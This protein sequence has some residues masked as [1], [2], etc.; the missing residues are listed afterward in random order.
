MLRG[1]RV[2]G[3]FFAFASVITLQT[4]A[5]AQ[6]WITDEDIYR[7]YVEVTAQGGGDAETIQGSVVVPIWGSETDLF[8]ADLRG[9][10][11]DEQTAEGNW[12]LGFR[13]MIDH[14]MIIGGY[15][16]YD[17][18]HT[19]SDNNFQQLTLGLELLTVDWD[20]RVNGYIPEYKAKV[21]NGA[22]Q[23]S[24]SNGTIVVNQGIEK[25]YYGTDYEVG[26]LFGE[27]NGGDTELRGYAG[28]YF[29]DRS[30][31]GYEQ[32]AGPR[33]RAE[34][35][36]H[37][38][39]FLGSGSRLMAG[40]QYQ[41]DELRGD[42]P[43]ALLQVRI[44]FGAGGTTKLTR[45]QRRMLNPIVRDIDVITNPQASGPTEHASI[46]LNGQ[47]IRE[48]TVIDADTENVAETIDNAP[49]GPGKIIVFDGSKGDIFTT[50][51]I[52]IKDG[53]FAG[54]VFQV[55]GLNSGAIVTYGNRAKIIN[56]SDG[57]ENVFRLKDESVLTGLSIY[58]GKNAV[59]ANDRR[60][61]MIVD[62]KIFG[63]AKSGIQ[64]TDSRK[65]LVQDNWVTD[66]GSDGFSLGDFKN[67]TI[68]GNRAINSGGN[69]IKTE[70]LS[71][72]LLTRNSATNSEDDGFDFG[73][74]K[75]GVVISNNIALNNKEDGFDFERIGERGRAED[76]A[77]DPI[78]T[79]NRAS[80]NAESGFEIEVF[81]NGSLLN[82]LA[83]GNGDNGFYID[84]VG[85]RDRRRGDR[86]E[87]A[88][89]DREV[90]DEMIIEPEQEFRVTISG[91]R[92]LNND[93]D[94][95]YIETFSDALFSNNIGN[96]NKY[97]G[98]HIIEMNGGEVVNNIANNNGEDGYIFEYVTKGIIDGN[99]ASANQGA[100]FYFGEVGRGFIFDK[101][102]EFDGPFF[103][104]I[105]FKPEFFDIEI[106]NNRSTNNASDGFQV[107]SMYGTLF[108]DNIASGNTGNGFSIGDA[109]GSQFSGNKAR[110]NE[111]NGFEI[112][113][114]SGCIVDNVATDNL[115]SG[116][117]VE[118]DFY[119]EV[120]NNTGSGNGDNDTFELDLMSPFS[121]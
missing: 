97:D 38:L 79:N 42:Q 74:V 40:I 27:W 54:G 62:N 28:G 23:A 63:S 113:W 33:V 86:R 120:S 93:T 112:E 114:F 6:D 19:Q 12:G 76:G 35:R 78:I 66:S 16:F 53:K 101:R 24:I 100:G 32:L 52:V 111:G 95:F 14:Q 34:M 98:I 88:F 17:L 20:V 61:F 26:Y 18:R 59:V 7:P 77:I 105:P 51:T 67:G 30:G 39:E 108:S 82:N 110:Q 64:L 65:G 91:N 9:T 1:Q 117:D 121:S 106:T 73:Q 47:R 41:Y 104:F 92:G 48:V 99:R 15:G 44:P 72:T 22:S 29:F 60:K 49:S 90:L 10:W 71:D 50:E 102:I 103:E 4:V 89:D 96:R 57:E 3:F 55:E 37:D 58:G 85:S 69:G 68:S 118:T 109:L 87:R 94:G 11:S 8:F 115:L 116:Y 107:E 5:S 2:S 84:R 56:I 36:L 83:S 31:T 43:S 75:S 25:A 21:A 70:K 13:H 119:T 80:G 45:I 46:V 81:S